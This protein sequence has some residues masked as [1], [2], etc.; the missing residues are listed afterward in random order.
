MDHHDAAIEKIS[1]TVKAFHEQKQP[2]RIYHGST[3][4]TRRSTRSVDTVVDLSE[5]NRVLAISADKNTAIVEPNVPM[6]ALVA[7]TLKHGLV[8]PVVM[9]FPG[10]TAGGAFSGTGGESSS[11]RWGTFDRIVNRVEMVLANGDVLWASED[12]NSDLFT[13]AAGSFG[14]LGIVTLLEV[15]L[16]PALSKLVELTYHPVKSMGEANQKLHGFCVT[17]P[18]WEYVDGIMY[19]KDSGVII[20]GRLMTEGDESLVTARYMRASDDWYYTNVQMK[21]ASKTSGWVDIV[22]IQDYLFRYDRGAFWCGK[23][24][25]EALRLPF[26]R[27]TRWLM[28]GSMHTRELFTGLHA[29]ES[30][31]ECI[32]QDLCIPSAKV[33]DF[34]SYTI[35]EFNIWPLWLCPIKQNAGRGLFQL[36]PAPLMVGSE[37]PTNLW[38]NVGLWGLAPPNIEEAIAANRRL[39]KSVKELGGYKWLYGQTFYTEDEFWSIYGKEEYSALRDKYHASTL[40]SAYDKVKTEAGT[41]TPRLGVWRAQMKIFRGETFLRKK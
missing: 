32:I 29:T 39:E 17:D 10:I 16:V 11:F 6:D 30:I 40:P 5:L 4:T 25:F 23:Y 1:S 37:S 24:T 18:K 38:I 13:G 31:M 34:V 20:T 27:F 28:D 15:Q 9:E 7:E 22:P 8:P 2:F 3:N 12:E 33:E 35:D 41:T 26:N 14:T 21:L 36:S 19:S